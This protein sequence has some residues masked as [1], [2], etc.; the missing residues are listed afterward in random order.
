[1]PSQLMVTLPLPLSPSKPLPILPSTS[2]IS[3]HL[4]SFLFMTHSFQ[5]QKT[6]YKR[7]SS[8]TQTNVSTPSSACSILGWYL[9]L[10]LLSLPSPLLSSPLVS[11]PI[12]PSIPLL[13]VCLFF[14]DTITRRN[15]EVVS[16]R[17]STRLTEGLLEDSQDLLPRTQRATLPLR[18]PAPLP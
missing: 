13:I 6:S 17:F 1:M 2:F 10:H 18:P 4:Y 8:K 16:P 14:A 5:Q 15:T 11:L 12:P 3:S 9:P 7:Y